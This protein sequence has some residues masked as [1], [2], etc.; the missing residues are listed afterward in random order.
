MTAVCCSVSHL[1]VIAMF[2]PSC[3]ACGV[4]FVIQDIPC[5]LLHLNHMTILEWFEINVLTDQ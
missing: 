1:L 2:V 3:D 5:W 4:M